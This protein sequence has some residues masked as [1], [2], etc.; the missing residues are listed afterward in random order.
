MNRTSQGPDHGEIAIFQNRFP[1]PSLRPKRE[2]QHIPGGVHVDARLRRGAGV[3]LRARAALRQ[4]TSTQRRRQL[5]VQ[6][7]SRQTVQ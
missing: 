3:P 1:V 6:E 7:D 4:A 5:R 2:I